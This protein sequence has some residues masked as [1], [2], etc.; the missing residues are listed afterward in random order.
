MSEAVSPEKLSKEGKAA[1]QRGDFSKAAEFF[2]SAQKAYLERG[3]AINAAEMA[4]NCSVAFLQSGD[5]EA[6]RRVVDGTPAIFA[7]AGDLRRQ[8]MALG[9]LAS[10][11]EAIE[12]LDEAVEIYQQSADVL[13]QAGEDQLR[14]NV[15]QSLSMLQF[16][17]GKQLQALASMNSGLE[18]VKHPNP[19]QSMLKKLLRIPIDMVTN[20][21][22]S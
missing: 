19:K 1:Y 11:L 9:N 18:G 14:A 7:Q 22:K 15:M 13:E 2:E 10:A 8:G 5:G 6:A 17:M 12:E 3:D 20:N 4:N 16:R 21:R